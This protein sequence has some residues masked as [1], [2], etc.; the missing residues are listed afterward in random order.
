VSKTKDKVAKNKQNTEKNFIKVNFRLQLSRKVYVPILLAT[1]LII[2][3][4]VTFELSFED[5]FFPRI[6]IGDNNLTYLTRSQASRVLDA[7]FSKRLEQKIAFT[8]LNQPYTID[9]AT[10][11]AK[12][13]TTAALS[14]GFSIGHSG[15]I[16]QQMIDQ[17]RVI[18]LGVN[19]KPTI[20]L[21]LKSQIDSLSGNVYVAP[22]E[23]NLNFS[24]PPDSTSSGEIK[25]KESKNGVGLDEDKLQKDIENYIVYGITPT[26]LPVKEIE[27]KVTTVK[28]ERA[29]QVLD[30]INSEPLKLTFE[31]GSWTIDKKKLITLINLE[32]PNQQL[33]DREKIDSYLKSLSS[34]VDQPVKEGQF[35]FDSNTKRV[36]AF[37]PSQEGRALD[38]EKLVSLINLALNGQGS[39][40]IELPVKI[41]SPKITTDSVNNLGI[42]ELIGKGVSNFAG[43]IPNRAYNVGLTATKINGVLIAPGETFSFINTVGDPT[44]ANGFKQAYVIKEGRTVLDDGG[45]VCQ[46]STTLFRAVLNAGLPIIE[47]TAHAYRVGY[48]EQGF[49]PGLDATTYYPTVDFKFKNDTNSHILIQAYTS[50]TTLTVDLYGTPDGRVSS[51]T[52]PIISSQTAPPPELRQDDPTIPKGVV[53]QVDWAAWGANVSFKRTVTRN[54][55][56]LVDETWRSNYKPWQAIYLVGTQ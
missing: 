49:P 37:V 40:N 47:R 14:E 26:I 51:V 22:I 8:Y 53:K 10:S 36:T 44:G 19:L 27:P 18:I 24:E 13:T 16:Y 54:G 56:T 29:K 38:K 52:T 41:V 28:V 6:Y 31:K 20:D 42:K 12:V 33:L 34:E 4:I 25:I 35:Q 32:E 2:L 39:K 17:A 48:Y 11:S 43:S 5:K 23:A 30:S 9:L 50:G 55:E 7:K 15:P 3:T 45:G 21:N 46:D 1:L